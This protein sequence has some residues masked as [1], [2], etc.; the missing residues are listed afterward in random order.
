MSR[1]VFSHRRIIAV[2]GTVSLFSACCH[3][4]KGH[5]TRQFVVPPP[6][7]TIT[8]VAYGDTR[9]GPW[10]L[11]DNAKQ[12]VHGKVVDDFLQNDGSI[13]AVIFTGDAF[14]TNF[15]LWKRKPTGVVF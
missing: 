1:R 12:A 5:V 7:S 10:G 8:V 2:L 4:P 9:T 13:D 3:Y 15:P 6:V 11:G 14:M